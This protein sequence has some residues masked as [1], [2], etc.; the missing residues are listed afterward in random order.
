MK[1]LWDELKN[2]QLV[3]VCQCGG[4]KAWMNYQKQ[5]YVM[6]FLIV[7]NKSYFRMRGQILMFHPLP[8]IVKVFNLVVQEG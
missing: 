2:F 8:P 6:Q 3:L 5:E 4:M 7:L 1:I